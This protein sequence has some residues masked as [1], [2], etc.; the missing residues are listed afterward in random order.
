MMCLYLRLQKA[1]ARYETE[2][3]RGYH[4]VEQLTDSGL[5]SVKYVWPSGRLNLLRPKNKSSLSDLVCSFRIPQA[6]QSVQCFFSL[7]L[8]LAKKYYEVHYEAQLIFA[9]VLH[10][11]L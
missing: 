9:P 10:H 5:K 8:I 7:Y 6:S 11:K 2:I 4:R 1:V 3:T